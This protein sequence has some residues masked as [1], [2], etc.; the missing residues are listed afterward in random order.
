MD[1][2]DQTIFTTKCVCHHF[3][4]NSCNYAQM[5]TKPR[6]HVFAIYRFDVNSSC[7]Y[8]NDVF[9]TMIKCILT[10]LQSSQK[11][12]SQWLVG[13]DFASLLVYRI[14]AMRMY[15]TRA[16]LHNIHQH[17]HLNLNFSLDL[18]GTAFEVALC[19]QL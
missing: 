16:C 15:E 6:K 1:Y 11:S 14:H 9:M 8:K 12:A 4:A 10:M 5:A 7:L 13:N 18:L 3:Q 2:P 19:A 17:R